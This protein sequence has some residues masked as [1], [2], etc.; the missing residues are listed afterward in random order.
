MFP[1][2]PKDPELGDEAEGLLTHWPLADKS[3]EEWEDLATRIDTRIKST[4]VGSTPDYLLEAPL[5]EDHEVQRRS[6]PRMKR[7]SEGSLAALAKAS[8]AKGD[9]P[10]AEREALAR[11][12]LSLA[13]KARSD[14]R[15]NTTVA[16][17]AAA[18]EA[19]VE[20]S[21]LVNAPPMHFLAGRQPNSGRQP[22]N[23]G[24]RLTP[25]RAATSATPATPAYVAVA[26]PEP[27]EPAVDRQRPV[28]SQRRERGPMWF[29]IAFGVLGMAAAVVMYVASTS[30]PLV[31]KSRPVA[32]AAPGP[33]I[34]AAPA[35]GGAARTPEATPALGE[36]DRVNERAGERTLLN[37]EDVPLAN[38]EQLMAA[39]PKDRTGPVRPSVRAAP[40][41]PARVAAGTAEPVPLPVGPSE[42]GMVMADSRG[43]LPD[44]PSTGAVQAAVGTVMGTA[45]ACVAGQDA[46]SRATVS[47]GSDGR[48]RSVV[49]AGPAAGTSAE[50]CLRNALGGA[51]VQPFARPSYSVNLTVRSH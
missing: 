16:H 12:L 22:P 7:P 15:A 40:A 17:N 19:S 2:D 9:G 14:G 31:S 13:V 46:P 23:S 1:E 5:L 35:P 47:F 10:D 18:Q 38:A 43:S 3:P 37:V 6:Q 32:V 51:R 45:R 26:S 20:L 48:V 30:Q 25:A 24:R 39:A 8:L 28:E 41:A 29:G 11:S 27:R 4:P 36:D 34:P 33:A 44:H 49:V 42:P 21:E 50:P